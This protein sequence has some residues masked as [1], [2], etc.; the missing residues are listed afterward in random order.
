MKIVAPIVKQLE[1]FSSNEQD[2]SGS[3]VFFPS[4]VVCQRSNVALL[5][6]ETGLCKIS[7]TGI[8][9]QRQG[10]KK[11]THFVFQKSKVDAE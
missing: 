9:Q 7:S 6:S 1:R 10:T 4:F 5:A 8:M 2:L 11:K 3:M